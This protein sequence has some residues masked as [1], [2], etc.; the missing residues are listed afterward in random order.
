MASSKASCVVND[1]W[2]IFHFKLNFLLQQ[3]FQGLKFYFFSVRLV[4]SES[5]LY[6]YMGF[7]QIAVTTDPA[8]CLQAEML[9]LHAEIPLFCL[10]MCLNCK[11][12]QMCSTGD[13]ARGW[14]GAFY[15][16]RGVNCPTQWVTLK[17]QVTVCHVW[18]TAV[19]SC[20]P[21]MTV[22][23]SNGM[24]YRSRFIAR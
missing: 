17:G 13:E 24:A 19:T 4:S 10:L 3:Q 15:K 7:V 2:W 23:L 18:P 21:Q 12:P 8:S 22:C 1:I 14:A 11:L 20:T 5:H 16:S 6:N 9:N